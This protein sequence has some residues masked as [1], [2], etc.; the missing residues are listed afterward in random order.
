MNSEALIIGFTRI[1]LILITLLTFNDYFKNRKTRQLDIALMFLSMAISVVVQVIVELK[2]GD[3]KTDPIMIIGSLAIVAQ[4]FLL[5]RLVQ[6]FYPVHKIV[7]KISFWGMILSYVILI[8]L[9]IILPK[10]APDPL[11][12][13]VLI[14]AYILIA[15]F[16][17]SQIYATWAFFWHAAHSKGVTKL[18]L[19]FAAASCALFALV[20]IIAA[21]TSTSP[22]LQESL[23]LFNQ[24]ISLFI[25][26]FYYFAFATPRFITRIWQLYELQHF[27]T[28]LSEKGANKPVESIL[29]QLCS[30]SIRTVGGIAAG[31]ALYQNTTQNF[32]TMIF[33]ETHLLSEKQISSDG[34]TGN[35]GRAQNSLL[36]TDSNELNQDEKD[37]LNELNSNVV[38]TTPIFNKENKWGVLLVFLMHPPLFP[39]DDIRLLEL[40]S[41]QCALILN[42]SEIIND[43]KAKEEE[44]RNAKE[45]SESANIAKSN[46]LA[47]MSHEL[48]TPLNAIIGYSEI[49]IEDAEDDG[50]TA[51]I[52]DL[53]KISG[54]G[55]HLLSLINDILDLSKIEAG[56]MELFIEK[57]DVNSVIRDVATTIQPLVQKNNNRLLIN[58]PPESIIMESDLTKIRQILFNLISNASKFTENGNITVDISTETLNND[59]LITFAVIDNGIGI[60]PEQMEKL[61]RNFSQADASTTRKYGGTGLGLALSRKFGQ[62]LGGDITVKSELGKGSTF[63][64]RLP[65]N[66]SL[67]QQDK[68]Q[69]L[70][71][72]LLS[73]PEIP[74]PTKNNNTILV[75]DDDL[76]IHDLLIR[77]LKKSTGFDV[78][79]ATTG[80]EGIRLARKYQ[81]LAITLDLVMP[82]IDGWQVLLELKKYPET[83]NIPVII[84]SMIDDKSMGYALGVSDYLTKPVDRD[85][86]TSLLQKYKC[87]KPK[88]PVLIVEDDSAQM[89]ILSRIL[90]SDNWDVLEAENGL[91]ALEKVKEKI[92]DLIILDLMMPE[93]DGFTFVMEIRKKENWHSIPIIVITAKE[94]T[95]EDRSRLNGYVKQILHK[96]AFTKE[97]LIN[98]IRKIVQ[99]TNALKN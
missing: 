76:T 17:F 26:I 56:K 19:N 13:S 23:K 65:V 45:I 90:K 48:R 58:Y 54:A 67:N 61:F 24:V 27:I 60:S 70:S 49:L 62:M 6:H 18:R 97:E 69:I 30:S 8:V 72:S 83:E 3:V 4:P 10:P 44:L 31:V 47:N 43:L 82:G 63:S 94:L 15:Y 95:D 40:F 99:N 41:E 34:L 59:K 81:P 53:Q 75:I 92:P 52:A 89:E 98:Y 22:Q 39:N 91:V 20:L 80:E 71:E 42:Y 57:L 73:A 86:L 74:V 21:A 77:N 9:T 88:C 2:G 37:I 35:T 14:A 87:D 55:K 29:Q 32:K 68:L 79:T 93:M 36:I 64:L 33:D 84:V 50:N 7:K 46:F 96:G 66:S 1:F 78:I 28:R 16:A 38:I 25:G 51:I 85:K 12:M 11:P 5:V